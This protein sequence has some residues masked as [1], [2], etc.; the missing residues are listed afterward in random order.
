VGAT[1]TYY[2]VDDRNPTGYAQVLEELPSITGAPLPAPTVRYVY[3]LDLV[4]QDYNSNGSTTAPTWVTRYY[5]Y[6]GLGSVRCLFN[7]SGTVTDHYTYDAFGTLIASLTPSYNPYRYTGEQWDPDLGMYYLRARYLNPA[8]GRF[9]SY[10]TFDG[11]PTDPLS[12]HKYLYASANPVNMIDPSGHN[13]D[14]ISFSAGS[15][16][17]LGLAALG[18]AAVVEAKTHAIG[19]LASALVTSIYGA[20]TA[21][22]VV[23]TAGAIAVAKT[24]EQVKVEVDELVAAAAEAANSRIFVHATTTADWPG[25]GSSKNVSIDPNRNPYPR[26]LDF[27]A[28]FYTW[29]L[30]DPNSAVSALQ[31]AMRWVSSPTHGVGVLA[32]FRMDEFTYQGLNKRQAMP[33]EQG[34]I[35]NDFSTG[36]DL[37]YGPVSGEGNWSWQYKFEGRGVLQLSKGFLGAVPL[38]K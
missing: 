14:A 23:T 1:T 31:S 29:Q 28:G 22:A 25:L 16:I 32:I 30:N 2:L 24:A 19:N 12:L 21:D 34:L 38:V 7:T 35:R 37:V 10:D 15:G 20:L 9:W 3:G 4:L 6:D 18:A 13:A 33:F 26:M 5:G 8:L 11:H 17:A 36:Y 27:G